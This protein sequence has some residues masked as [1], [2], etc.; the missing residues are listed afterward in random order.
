[1]KL[2]LAIVVLLASVSTLSAQTVPR[3]SPDVAVGKAADK[4]AG[5]QGDVLAKIRKTLDPW[6]PFEETW[7]AEATM[8]F[9]ATYKHTL[10]PHVELAPGLLARPIGHAFTVA[11]VLKGDVPFKEVVSPDFGLKGE[12]FPDAL[13]T[14]RKYLVL[15]K[16]SEGTLKRMQEPEAGSVRLA[17]LG[18]DEV[19]A[20]VDLS[21]GKA[22]AEAIRIQS[23]RSGSYQGF[24]FTPEKWAA[25]R[26]AKKIDLEQQ[27]QL[28]PF[29]QNVVLA[30]GATLGQVRSYLGKPGY[31]T[32]NAEGFT[33]YY[34]FNSGEEPQQGDI[35]GSLTAHF[36]P[37]LALDQYEIHFTRCEITRGTTSWMV[38]SDDEHKKLGLPL[39]QNKVKAGK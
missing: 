31:Q 8:I 21:Q 15:L 23:T 11:S 5:P 36:T 10:L 37:G 4:V 14:G 28:V 29:L 19:V 25:I 12:R 7:A 6:H 22:E 35:S 27:K 17:G 16:P 3:A 26:E 39:V 18:G 20:I 2:D 38:L 13:V 34:D 9:T 33:Y 1:M 24:E 30:K 32:A